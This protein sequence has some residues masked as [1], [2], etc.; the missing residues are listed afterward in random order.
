MNLD[1]I[2]LKDKTYIFEPSFQRQSAKLIKATAL[3]QTQIDK[4]ITLYKS[5]KNN[6]KLHYHKIV[7][8]KDKCRK[9]IALLD[10]NQQ[11]KILLSE[12]QDK[13]YFIFIG[14]HKKY[15]RL[16]KEC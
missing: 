7:C 10:T 12:Q 11:Y 5:E 16:N 15:D 13:I 8:K 1:F 2:K 9:S 6:P 4:T 14:H 3:T